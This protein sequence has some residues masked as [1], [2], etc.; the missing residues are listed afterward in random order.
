MFRFIQTC[1]WEVLQRG[2]FVI[3]KTFL[4]VLTILTQVLRREKTFDLDV[5][6]SVFQVRLSSHNIWHHSWERWAGL[7]LWLRLMLL[8]G[9]RKSSTDNR[10]LPARHRFELLGHQYLTPLS[11]LSPISHLCSHL[12]FRRLDG[13]G[14]K[15]RVWETKGRS[16]RPRV[17]ICF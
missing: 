5:S 14:G 4:I 11:P 8:R 9:Q 17:G 15:D 3:A 2:H 12:G 7:T 1:W 6:S 10:V 13:G 16:S